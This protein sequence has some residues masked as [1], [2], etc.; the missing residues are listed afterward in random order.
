M[1]IDIIDST[2]ALAGVR[3]NWE[4]VYEADPEAQFFLSRTWLSKWLPSIGTPWF[5][6]AVGPEADVSA[7]S[8]FFPLWLRTKAEKSGGFHNGIVMGGNYAADYTGLLCLPGQEEQAIAAFADGIKQLNWTDFRLD[9]LRMTDRRVALL[10]Q[11]FSKTEFDVARRERAEDGI[12]LGICPVASLPGDWDAY[13]ESRLS[14]NMRQKIRRLLRQVETSDEFRITHAQKD[15]IGRDLDILLRFWT[16]RWGPR[17]GQRLDGILKNS[18]LMLRHALDAGSLFLPVLWQGDRS[19]RSPRWSMPASGPSS[20]TWPLATR[21]ST[22]RSPGSC[23]MPTA[24]AM[25]SAADSSPM[26]DFLRGNEPYK[27]S[28]GAERAPEFVFR[29]YDEGQEESRRAVGSEEP[30]VRAA[31]LDGPPSRRSARRGRAR[32]SADPRRRPAERGRPLRPGAN[33]A[34]ARRARGSH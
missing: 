12:D 18:R 22:V 4:A 15:T 32:L 13:L 6:L 14:A 27:Y 17:K 3:A 33:H 16:Q 29:D 26:I 2:K 11:A 21:R 34:E 10:M 31:D 28:F 25:P 19:A 23:C 20:S 7:Y 1:R 5:V 8:A 9:D 24:S 30:A